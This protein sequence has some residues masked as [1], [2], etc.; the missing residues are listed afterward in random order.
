MRFAVW[1][2]LLLQ[3]MLFVPLATGAADAQGGC[4]TR[5]EQRKAVRSGSVVRPGKVGRELG[6]K[7]LS[8]RLCRGG[9]GLVWQMQVLARDGRVRAHVVDARSG[10]RIR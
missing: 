9:G 3:I 7:V 8:L 4:L 2:V 10:Q 6:G 5:A 1:I